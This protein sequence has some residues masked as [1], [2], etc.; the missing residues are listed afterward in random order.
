MADFLP[1]T[2]ILRYFIPFVMT[3]LTL[4]AIAHPGEDC[5]TSTSSIP[6]LPAM[7]LNSSAGDSQA[8]ILEH[9]ARETRNF[10]NCLSS[11]VGTD[12]GI[13]IR[14][15][16]APHSSGKI[17]DGSTYYVWE[18]RNREKYCRT[19]IFT[20]RKTIAS[21]KSSGNDCMR[22]TGPSGNSVK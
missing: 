1:M 7:T 10:N 3:S 21:W 16:G 14:T 2:P 8:V 15:W 5:I 12:I 13:L 20:K 17:P 9:V 4:S 19:T 11:W 18:E 22:D 6:Q